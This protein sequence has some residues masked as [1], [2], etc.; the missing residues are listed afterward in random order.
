MSGWRGAPSEPGEEDKTF[1]FK[2]K[3]VIGGDF[4]GL[5]SVFVQEGK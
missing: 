5:G 2:P 1:S 3:A 4:E